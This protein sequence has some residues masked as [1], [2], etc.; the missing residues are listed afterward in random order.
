LHLAIAVESGAAVLAPADAVMAAAA[1]ALGMAV[2]R[3][4]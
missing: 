1:T 2:E 4:D 3:F